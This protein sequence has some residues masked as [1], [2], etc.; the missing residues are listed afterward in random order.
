MTGI[1]ESKL[2]FGQFQDKYTARGH[3]LNFFVISTRGE[4]SFWTGQISVALLFI[5]K[6]QIMPVLSIL[7]LRFTYQKKIDRVLAMKIKQLPITNHQ[8]S[9]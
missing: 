2:E 6:V 4:N 3:N 7:G 9:N 1:V 5:I 8:L